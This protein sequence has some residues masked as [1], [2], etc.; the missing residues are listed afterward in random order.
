MAVIVLSKPGPP[1]PLAKGAVTAALLA[2]LLTLGVLMVPVL[3]T[4]G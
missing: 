1:M 2:A 4:T 3:G